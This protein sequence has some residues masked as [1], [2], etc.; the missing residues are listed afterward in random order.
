[1]AIPQWLRHIFNHYGIPYETH[2]HPP[3]Y[4]APELAEVEHVSGYRVAKTVF[5][6]GNGQPIAVVL[7]SCSRLDLERVKAVLGMAD[8]RLASEPEI[9]G[10]FKGCEPGAVP[11]LRLRGD[12]R[13]LMD[14]SLAHLG[15]LVFAAGTT[16]DAVTVPFRKWYRAVRPG[17]GRFTQQNNGHAVRATPPSVLVVEDETATNELFCRLLEREGFTCHHAEEGNQALALAPQ[18]RPSAILLDLMLPDMSGFEVYEKLRQSGPLKR[19]P[20]IVV[21]ALSDEA[22]RQRGSDLGADA[23]LTKPF[24]PA[25]LVSE[26]QRILE[27]V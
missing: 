10:W 6:V 23:Y 1:M 5:L 19:I 9:G 22:S 27:P 25:A 24:A 8:L 20:V 14:R 11:P 12:E 7:P 4:T 18:V 3:V 17:V 16:E 13:I 2:H 26:L 15:H 21:T